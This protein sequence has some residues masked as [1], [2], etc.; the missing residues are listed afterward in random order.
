MLSAAAHEVTPPPSLPALVDAV[1][2]RA[3]RWNAVRPVSRGR[4]AST[5]DFCS[6]SVRRVSTIAAVVAAGSAWNGL[7]AAAHVAWQHVPAA[8]AVAS[9]VLTTGS[10]RV[11]E[12]DRAQGGWPWDWLAFRSPGAL[13][14][15]AL[16]LASALIELTFAKRSSGVE[17]LIDAA[18]D[19]D[20]G[21]RG[22]RKT[23][24][25]APRR[26]RT[27]SLSRDF[28]VT[29]FLGGWSFP[30]LS[31]EQQ[32]ARPLFEVAGAVWLLAKTWAVVLG[33]AALRLAL[34]RR[35]LLEATRATT[36]WRVP[37]ALASFAMTG[38]WNWWSPERAVELLVSGSLVAIAGLASVAA[39]QR[40]RHGV[41]S[42]GGDGHLSPFL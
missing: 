25:S 35:H 29:G 36:V 18:A 5:W 23:G 1:A 15:L 24:G 14:A 16:L 28:A 11:Q 39:I 9:V 21:S 17:H 41:F 40:V 4:T 38:V 32:D 12:I 33:L 3:S 42:P 10:L 30:G 20:G 7:R 37:L 6:W 31:P 26:A 8:I 13:L 22:R 19:A 2:L 34:P 27:G